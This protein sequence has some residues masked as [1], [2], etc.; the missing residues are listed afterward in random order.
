[1]K[2]HELI[3]LLSHAPEAEVTLSSILVRHAKPEPIDSTQVTLNNEAN[4]WIISP[5]TAMHPDKFI[6][7]Q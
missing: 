7:N 6:S 5:P 1:M 2:A 4:T 3:S